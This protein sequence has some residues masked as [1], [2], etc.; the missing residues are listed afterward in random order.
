MEGW[1]SHTHA[2][3]MHAR[4][5]TAHYALVYAC[6]FEMACISN[7]VKN[8]NEKYI[9]FQ[10]GNAAF[11]SALCCARTCKPPTQIAQ[12]SNEPKT[13]YEPSDSKTFTNKVLARTRALKAYCKAELANAARK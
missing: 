1:D 4:T 11:V 10:Q 9:A 5:P 3:A 12:A 8:S 13:V 7:H 2:C 6:G